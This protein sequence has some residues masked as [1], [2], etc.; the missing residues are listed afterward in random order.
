MGSPR[1][2]SARTDGDFL[3]GSQGQTVQVWDG[4]WQPVGAPMRHRGEVNSVLFVPA[5]PLLL[6]G[7]DDNTARFWFAPTSHPVG[8]ALGHRASVSAVAISPDGRIGATASDDFQAKLW[9]VP[10][11]VTEEPERLTGWVQVLT[12]QEMDDKGDIPVLAADDW[13]E[14]RE[15]FYPLPS[16]AQQERPGRPGGG[17]SR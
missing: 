6:S 1:S 7:S 5:G 13:Q 4:N 16:L 15:R 9:P 17:S 10:L 2:P 11:P 3:T 8:P 14:R 12:G